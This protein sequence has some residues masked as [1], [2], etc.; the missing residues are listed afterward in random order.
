MYGLKVYPSEPSPGLESPLETVGVSRYSYSHFQQK[1]HIHELWPG[2]RML[3]ILRQMAQN[4]AKYLGNKNPGNEA[5]VV[6]KK[7]EE[8]QSVS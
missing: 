2:Q 6:D 1:H 7:S 3:S 5:M 8:N 4:V